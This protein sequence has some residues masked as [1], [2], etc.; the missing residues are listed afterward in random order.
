MLI[1]ELK[2]WGSIF[3]IIALGMHHK[4]FLSHPIDHVMAL[5]HAGV[6]GLGMIHP[7]V[8]SFVIYLI[9]W[10]PRFIYRIFKRNKKAPDET[11]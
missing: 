8:F 6:Y 5:P 10:I 7:I 3:I 4:E 1:R 2:V 9:S 11:I